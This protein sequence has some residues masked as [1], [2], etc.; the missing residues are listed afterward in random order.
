MRTSHRQ[1]RKRILQTVEH[2]SQKTRPQFYAHLLTGKFH[3]IPH[4]DAVGHLINLH[5]GN[6]L[7][8][9]DDF[10]LETFPL[11][12]NIANFILVN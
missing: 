3:R 2:L 5:A 12:E 7:I 9:S 11:N 6:S 10:C 4:F 1:I 8:D